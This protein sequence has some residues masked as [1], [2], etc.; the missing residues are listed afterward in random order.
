MIKNLF[1][2]FNNYIYS[3]IFVLMYHVSDLDK[4]I[5]IK[6]SNR[7]ICQI[8]QEVMRINIQFF[9]QIYKIKLIV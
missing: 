1:Y 8:Q 7:Q 4:Q 6:L 2:I 9:I 5:N 3:N